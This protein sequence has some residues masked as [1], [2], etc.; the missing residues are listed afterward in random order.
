MKTIVYTI[1]IFILTLLT[2]SCDN[3]NEPDTS[4]E[5]E[6]SVTLNV[7]NQT[8]AKYEY[9]TLQAIVNDGR[10]I[11]EIKWMCGDQEIGNEPTINYCFTEEGKYSISANVTCSDKNS[12]VASKEVTVSGTSLRYSLENFDSG[13]TWIMG[14]R[15]NTYQSDS[16]ENSIKGIESCISLNGVVNVVEID[17]RRTKD[18]ILILMHDET[19]DRTT[20]GTGKVKDLTL[21]E[22][23]SYQLK[24][25]DGTITSEKVPTLYDAL[26]AGKGKIYFDL[27][28]KDVPVKEVYDI[29]KSAGM[30]E[31]VFFYTEDMDVVNTIGK[32]DPA[33]VIYPQCI[34]E[35]DVEFLASQGIKMAQLSLSKALD[36]DFPARLQDKGLLWTTNILDMKGYDYDSKML[37]GN[38]DGVDKLLAKNV[39][40]I[41]TDYPQLLVKY[42]EEKSRR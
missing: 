8:P 28:I 13:K 17:P 2:T 27:D 30:L 31:Q 22:I 7:S 16:P 6:V 23:Q 11:D 19:I 40:M 36:T 33:P 26:M 21:E 42:L 37:E 14:H 41:Q 4:S 35:S 9:I 38:Y 25:E 34:E 5:G 3:N 10:N 29:V 12:G 18:G 15:G 39:N 32:Y 1:S 20:T 24:L